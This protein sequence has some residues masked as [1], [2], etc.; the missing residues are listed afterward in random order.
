MECRVATDVLARAQIH[1][2]IAVHA[3]EHERRAREFCAVRRHLAL[4]VF[5]NRLK[6]LAYTALGREEFDKPSIC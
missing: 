5:P 4:K 1:P 6:A 2:R 3:R